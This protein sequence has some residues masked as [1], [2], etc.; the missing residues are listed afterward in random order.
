MPVRERLV[1]QQGA[2]PTENL[3]PL[4]VNRVIL[5]GHVGMDPQIHETEDGR[6]IASFSLATTDQWRDERGIK[7]QRT[8][9]HRVVVYNKPLADL[10]EKAVKRGSQIYVVGKL[11]TN[12][13]TDGDGH[14]QEGTVVAVT[15]RGGELTIIATPKRAPE[16]SQTEQ[17]VTPETKNTTDRN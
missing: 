6:K 2:P 11:R 7:H 13:W 14:E 4:S 3:L 17:S 15:V 10:T 16:A 9:W 12:K 5:F 8:N 1:Q